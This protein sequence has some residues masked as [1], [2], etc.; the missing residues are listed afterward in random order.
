MSKTTIAIVLAV[1][2]IPIWRAV[3]DLNPRYARKMTKAELDGIA[4]GAAQIVQNFSFGAEGDTNAETLPEQGR[5]RK[6]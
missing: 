6:R 1:N 3:K 4:D 2:G 5:K